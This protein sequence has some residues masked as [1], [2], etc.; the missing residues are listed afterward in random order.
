MGKP[1]FPIPSPGG[2]VWAGVTLPRQPICIAALCAMRIP[3][4]H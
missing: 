3:V 1:D 4:L 2:R